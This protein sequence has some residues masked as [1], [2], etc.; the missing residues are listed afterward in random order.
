MMTYVVVLEVNQNVTGQT[1]SQVCPHNH[2]SSWCSVGHG[3]AAPGQT[4]HVILGLTQPDFASTQ[5]ECAGSASSIQNF[6]PHEC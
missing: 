6:D 5:C 4:F 1:M 3:A 2:S